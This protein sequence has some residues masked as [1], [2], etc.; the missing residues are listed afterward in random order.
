MRENLANMSEE[1]VQQYKLSVLTLLTARKDN[2]YKEG[3]Q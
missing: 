1:T 3:K 2:L